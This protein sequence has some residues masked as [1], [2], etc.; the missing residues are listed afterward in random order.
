MRVLVALV[1]VYVLVHADTPPP[2]SQ[3]LSEQVELL[4]EHPWADYVLRSDPD[5]DKGVG[6]MADGA[7]LLFKIAFDAAINETRPV[8]RRQAVRAQFNL[9]AMGAKKNDCRPEDFQ[10]QLAD[11]HGFDP[12]E[13]ENGAEFLTEEAFQAALNAPNFF[14]MKQH[15]GYD[16]VQMFSEV[17]AADRGET[18][19]AALREEL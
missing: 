11:E 15:G 14:E 16:L 9:L 13:E 18:E 10:Q 19:D 2:M 4:K 17:F 1:S 6:L 5:F 8:A 3:A 7:K 12:L